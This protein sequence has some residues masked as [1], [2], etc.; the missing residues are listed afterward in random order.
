[1]R[2]ALGRYVLQP[3]ENVPENQKFWLG[4]TLLCLI[5][6]FLIHNPF[7]RTT[8][9]QYKEGDIASESIVSPADITV[10]DEDENKRIRESVRSGVTPIFTFEAKRADEAVQSFR[11]AWENLSRN[12]NTSNTNSP[13]EAHLKPQGQWTRNSRPRKSVHFPKQ[14][15]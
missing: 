3:I 14:R 6:T 8:T 2:K 5:T 11:S 15:T 13:N 7:W 4:F 12:V 10:I 1:M 9:E